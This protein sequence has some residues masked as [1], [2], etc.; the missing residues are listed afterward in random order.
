MADSRRSSLVLSLSPLV[1]P[2]APAGSPPPP[3]RNSAS[4]SRSFSRA[5]SPASTLLLFVAPP[6]TTR[7][8]ISR[9]RARALP[10]RASRSIQSRARSSRW[11]R[12]A[13]SMTQSGSP[14]MDAASEVASAPRAAYLARLWLRSHVRAEQIRESDFPLGERSVRRMGTDQAS[15][16]PFQSGFPRCPLGRLH[17]RGRRRR[18]A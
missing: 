12:S 17:A 3:S 11:R 1:R 7:S 15:S 10:R 13:C 16:A 9:S 6:R 8:S 5:F 18:C 14:A 4:S 2:A